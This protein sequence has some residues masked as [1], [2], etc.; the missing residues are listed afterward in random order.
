[1]AWE[2]VCDG[3]AGEKKGIVVSQQFVMLQNYT[4]SGAKTKVVL[5]RIKFNSKCSAKVERCRINS[6]RVMSFG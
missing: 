3:E 5:L 4:L 2:T 1:M 6:G